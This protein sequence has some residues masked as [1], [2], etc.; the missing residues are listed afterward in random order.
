[1]PGPND[2]DDGGGSVR[3]LTQHVDLQHRRHRYPTKGGAQWHSRSH[4]IEIPFV[5]Q[6]D[7]D[8]RKH[9]AELADHFCNGI[10]FLKT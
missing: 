8:G 9:F 10:C 1:M 5:D 6:V 7:A 3:E 4:H 2:G